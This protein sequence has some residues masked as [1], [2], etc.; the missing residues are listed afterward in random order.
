LARREVAAVL[1][2]LLAAWL[3]LGPVVTLR[4]W[5]VPL[6]APY[7]WLYEYVPGFVAGRAPARFAMIAACFGALAAAWGLRYLRASAAGRRASWLLCGAF[8]VET[9]AVPL[10][11]SRQWDVEGV[12]A[13]PAWRDGAPSPVVTMI[14]ALPDEAVVAVLP[15]G[16]I[17]HETRALFDSAHH[18]RRM[19]NGYSSWTPDAHTQLAVALRDPL[20]HAPEAVAALRAAGAT[21]VVVHEAAWMRDK[22]PHVTQRLIEAGATPVGRAGEVALLAL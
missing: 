16:E 17:F 11:L 19:L 18:W 1:L 3:A 15:F 13:L 12:A 4:G 20:R 10:P 14:R 9:A 21:H 2:S 8:L 22:G 5:P 6:P 7:R